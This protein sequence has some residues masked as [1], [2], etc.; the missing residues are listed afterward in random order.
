M[1]VFQLRP[2]DL[3]YQVVK[4]LLSLLFVETAPNIYCVYS[5]IAKFHVRFESTNQMDVGFNAS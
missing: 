2:N 5:E 4:N 1:S 3:R